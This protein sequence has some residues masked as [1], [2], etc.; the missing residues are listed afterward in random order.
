MNTADPLNSPPIAP[1]MT[2]QA[3]SAPKSTSPTPEPKKPKR[4]YQPQAKVTPATAP[5]KRKKKRRR[6]SPTPAPHTPPKPTPAPVTTTS[7]KTST[8]RYLNYQQD[9]F[10]VGLYQDA[11]RNDLF[12]KG[13]ASFA[14]GGMVW[15]M[16]CGIS[17]FITKPSLSGNAAEVLVGAFAGMFMLWGAAVMGLVGLAVVL[18]LAAGLLAVVADVVQIALDLAQRACD[19]IEEMFA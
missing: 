13:F 15:A 11:R 17:F 10:S 12:F 2:H 3:G 6:S 4:S 7:P 14:A 8:K 5:R 1:V 19:G 18:G 16:G 9:L